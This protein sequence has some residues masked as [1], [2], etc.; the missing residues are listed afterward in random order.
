MIHT[1]SRGLG[2]E[3]CTDHV[4][5]MENAM[6]HDGIAVPD[7]QLA[8]VLSV[9]PRARPSGGDGRGRKLRT[10][11]SATVTEATRRVFEQETKTSLDL[12]SAGPGAG[13][14]DSGAA[15]RRKGPQ[16]TQPSGVVP[17]WWFRGRWP[18]KWRHTH[19]GR[20]RSALTR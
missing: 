14:P 7:R 16:Q 1:G 13:R 10:R 9:P 8:C 6:S 11:Q 18:G 20:A 15:S 3:I 5:Q 12:L 2:D 4:R 19:G 17:E